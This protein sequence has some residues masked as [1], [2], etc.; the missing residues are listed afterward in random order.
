MGRVV[1][2]LA[3]TLGNISGSQAGVSILT[4]SP[5]LYSR[6]IGN[7]MSVGYKMAPLNCL[8]DKGRFCCCVHSHLVPTVAM[9][10]YF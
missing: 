1:L 5:K 3:H 8:S 2:K 9:G 6:N 7:I 10:I 4:G